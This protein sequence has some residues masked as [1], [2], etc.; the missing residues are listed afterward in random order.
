VPSDFTALVSLEMWGASRTCTN[1]AA[2]I[3]LTSSF[4]VPPAGPAATSVALGIAPAFTAGQ[5]FRYSI[6]GVF[7]A[8]AAQAQAGVNVNHGGIGGTID[9]YGIML[10]YT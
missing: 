3:T 10:G 4:G 7:A 5:L 8:L 1:A 2:P 6:A 9:Y